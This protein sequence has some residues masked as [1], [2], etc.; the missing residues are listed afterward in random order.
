MTRSRF[1]DRPRKSQPPR[2]LPRRKRQPPAEYVL[3]ELLPDG[4]PSLRGAVTAVLQEGF[5]SACAKHIDE[6]VRG[7]SGGDALRLPPGRKPVT[8]ILKDTNA[9]PMPFC[10]AVTGCF[11][12]LGERDTVFEVLFLGVRRH[13]LRRGAGAA[14][15]SHLKTLLV[16]R[17]REG[18]RTVLCVS[19]KADGPAQAFWSAQG[20]E[21]A[22]L[23]LSNEMTPFEDWD[24]RQFV[25]SG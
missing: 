21:P 17:R 24:P 20:M 18:G 11:Y 12:D 8:F 13:A 22:G 4:D 10:G 19:V 2:Q 25:V 9:D 5:N 1:K 6:A 15:V 7:V 14:L 23:R 16:G 3:A